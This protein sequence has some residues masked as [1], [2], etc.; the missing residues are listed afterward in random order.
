MQ[1]TFGSLFLQEIYFSGNIR[2]CPNFLDQA[3]AAV[4]M[5]K[6]NHHLGKLLVC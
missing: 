3:L 2:R 1:K 5:Q 6:L 4:T